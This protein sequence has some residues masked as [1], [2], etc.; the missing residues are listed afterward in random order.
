MADPLSITVSIVALV[1]VG[2]QVANVV[3]FLADAGKNAPTELVEL[4]AELSTLE[5]ILLRV[6]EHADLIAQEGQCSD[7]DKTLENL[8]KILRDTSRKLTAIDKLFRGGA[9]GKVKFSLTWSSAK[10]DLQKLQACLER[11]KT[12]MLLSLQLMNL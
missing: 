10:K 5:H 4:E 7:L 11:N 3:V 12:S 2:V 9:V 1:K 8:Q 6:K